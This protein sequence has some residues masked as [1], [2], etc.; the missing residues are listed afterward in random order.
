MRTG[1]SQDFRRLARLR[2]IIRWGGAAAAAA[3]TA[4]SPA[5]E[6]PVPV[7]AWLATRARRAISRRFARVDKD[8]LGDAAR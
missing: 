3:G 6:P 7:S 2:I 1:K 5:N 4:T 8:D